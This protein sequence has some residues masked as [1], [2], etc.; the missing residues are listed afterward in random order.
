VQASQILI[1]EEQRE[2]GES[3]EKGR[4]LL[5]ILTSTKKEGI[6]FYQKGGINIALRSIGLIMSDAQLIVG[7]LALNA[8]LT[9][10]TIE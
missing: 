6:N 3:V 2:L 1:S 4:K 10:K 9:N 7:S 8:D 5:E